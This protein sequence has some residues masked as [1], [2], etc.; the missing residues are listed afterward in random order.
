MADHDHAD[1]GIS[2]CARCGCSQRADGDWIH[3]HGRDYCEDCGEH[4]A[5]CADCGNIYWTDE[6][7]VCPVCPAPIDLL[8]A[9]ERLDAAAKDCAAK[10]AALLAELEAR[11]A[12]I[13]ARLRT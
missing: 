10:S 2:S 3:F 8:A 11:Q 5:Y 6:H 4:A 1:A 13:E 7:P 9:A 12:R